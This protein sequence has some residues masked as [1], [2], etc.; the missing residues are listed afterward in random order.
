MVKHGVFFGCMCSAVGRNVQFCC[1]RY[2]MCMPD[3]FVLPPKQKFRIAVDSDTVRRVG[4]IHELMVREGNM[5]LSDV[6]S[7]GDISILTDFLCSY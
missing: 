3:L 1:E 2:G 5:S 4:K 6:F 7:T